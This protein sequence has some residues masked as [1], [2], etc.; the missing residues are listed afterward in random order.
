VEDIRRR[1][2]SWCYRLRFP[3]GIK[4]TWHVCPTIVQS[5]LPWSALAVQSKPR[6]FELP[7][8]HQASRQIVRVDVHESL[9]VGEARDLVA[10]VK[11]LALYYIASTPPQKATL[12][13]RRA[14]ARTG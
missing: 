8:A 6:H 4:L 1:L 11:K 7:N 13:A 10:A 5:G 9:G 14:V 2:N 3:P 12:D